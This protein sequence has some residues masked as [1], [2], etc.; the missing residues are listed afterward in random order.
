MFEIWKRRY[1]QYLNVPMM[2]APTRLLAKQTE[3]VEE[4][5][6]LAASGRE[7]A[8]RTLSAVDWAVAREIQGR[9]DAAM[10]QLAAAWREHEKRYRTLTIG[11]T[12]PKT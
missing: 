12:A 6:A 10:V 3:N 9:A 8:R 7:H 1:G 11:K 2:R 5:L 4:L